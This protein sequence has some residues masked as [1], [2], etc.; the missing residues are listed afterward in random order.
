MRDVGA[1]VLEGDTSLKFVAGRLGLLD[2]YTIMLVGDELRGIVS[3]C[4][5]GIGRLLDGLIVD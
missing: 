2:L 4:A 3:G 5:E 1:D